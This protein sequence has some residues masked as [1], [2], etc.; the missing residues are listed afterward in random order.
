MFNNNDKD[1]YKI[2]EVSKDADE[3]TIKKSYRK[4]ALKYHPDRNKENK[5]ESEKKFKEISKAYEVLSDSNK[6]KTY[7]NFGLDAVNNGGVGGENPFDLFGNIFSQSNGFDNMFNMG[8]HSRTRKNKPRSSPN[9]LKNLDLTLEDVYCERKF[10]INFDKTIKCRQCNGSGAKDSSCIK[11]CKNCDGSGITISIKTFGPGMISQSQTTCNICKGIGKKI[12]TKCE[13]CKGSKYESI[14]KRINVKLEHDNKNRDKLVIQGEAHEDVDC[15]ITGNLILELNIKEHKDFTRVG[16]DLFITKSI[17]LVDALCGFDLTIVHLDNRKFLVK[18]GD[19][20]SP[21]TMKKING[22]G[23]NGGDLVI[24]FEIIFPK[25]LSKERKE[26]ISKLLPINKKPDVNYE[27]YELKML[28]NYE[29]NFED[30]YTPNM[31]ENDKEEAN[32]GCATQ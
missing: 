11:I 31:E 4:M 23:F 25:T 20:I 3:A 6:R 5:E 13:K 15:D 14:K 30:N 28:E 24:S 32:I 8:A 19:I 2:L 12:T 29:K 10:N 17:N 21:K 26:Y 1:L 7:D 22:E 16:N 9:I 18:T 27:G